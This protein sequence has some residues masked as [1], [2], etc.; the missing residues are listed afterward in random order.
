[1]IDTGLTEKTAAGHVYRRD[2]YRGL[3]ARAHR[4]PGQPMND[5]AGR[6]LATTARYSGGSTGSPT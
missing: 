1:M 2:L 4:S 6:S 3:P 5:A